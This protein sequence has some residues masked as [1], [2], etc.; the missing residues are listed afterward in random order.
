V[1]PPRIAILHDWLTTFGGAERCLILFH[2]LFPTAPIYTLVCDRKNLSPELSNARIITSFID[3]LPDAVNKYPNYLP[4]MPRAVEQWNLND[5][6][7]VLSSCHCCVKGAL[8]REDQAHICYCYTPIRYIWDL[9][10][11]Y[12]KLTKLSGIKRK[13]FEWTS[14]YLRMWDYCAAQRVDRFV[15]I[16]ETVRRRIEKTYQRKSALIYPPVNTD[17]FYP[18]PA[19][20]HDYYLVVSRFVPYK[21]VDLAIRAFASRPEALLVV[22]AG[23]QEN[24]LKA[25]ATPNIEF[26]GMVSD[27]ELRMLYQNARAL[28]FTSFEDFGLTPVEIQACGRPVVAFGKGGALETVIENK[29]GVFFHEESTDSINSAVN[30]LSGLEMN[31]EDCRENALRFN[32]ERFMSEIIEMLKPFM[33]EKSRPS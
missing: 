10:H 33:E 13:V 23:P 12:L 31:P 19:A 22:G 2:K 24:E 1:R 32:E 30:K 17:N 11:E 8:T 28:I 7:I 21:R 26:L 6:D 4:L 14:H 20:E 29:T 15:A 27:T 3:K 25:I 16:S 9:H 18:D 5:Y